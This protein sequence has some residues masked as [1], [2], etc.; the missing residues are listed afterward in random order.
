MNRLV[1]TRWPMNSQP[2][3]CQMFLFE[4]FLIIVLRQ[5]EIPKRLNFRRADSFRWQAGCE[6]V[7]DDVEI[8]MH[9]R[10]IF[11]RAAARA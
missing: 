8:P 11:L 10:L 7:T 2:L 9:A 1:E 6:P 5:L 3:S 4:H